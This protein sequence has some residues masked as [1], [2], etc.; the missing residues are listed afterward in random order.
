M[1]SPEDSPRKGKR[2]PKA[3]HGTE[4]HPLETRFTKAMRR[5]LE[6]IEEAEDKV[7]RKTVHALRV[8]IRRCRSVASGMRAVDPD[9]GWVELSREGRKLF[10]CLGSLRDLQVMK[11]WLRALAG[12]EDPVRAA[13]EKKIR[14][15]EREQLRRAREALKRFDRK[16]WRHWAE[17]LSAHLHDLDDGRRSLEQIARE[18]LASV[19]RLH[20][21][22]LRKNS[23]D[24]WHELRIAVKRFRY[25][26]EN[27][28]PDQYAE[29][30]GD[31]GHF[32]DLLGEVHDLDVLADFL[33]EA[34]E[35]WT[36]NEKRRWCKRIETERQTRLEEYRARTGGKAGFWKRAAQADFADAARGFNLSATGS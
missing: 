29:W 11:G 3:G 10:R 33:P 19:T 16:R 28:F 7:T 4:T 13:L 14:A 36:T 17:N 31:L 23:I 6:G 22:A 8:S 35:A 18:R 32:Q 9:I 1:K 25:T 20:R 5:V 12:R 15:R 27:F 34:G 2:H 30:G 24:T 21:K 26:I